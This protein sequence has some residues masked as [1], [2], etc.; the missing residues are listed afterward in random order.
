MG[1]KLIEGLPDGGFFGRRNG[2]EAVEQRPD[3]AVPGKVLD[4]E[5]FKELIRR[6]GPDIRLGLLTQVCDLCLHGEGEK[7]TLVATEDGSATHPQSL[8]GETLLDYA[9]ANF[10]TS[11]N[12]EGLLTASSARILRL[13]STCFL[14]RPLTSSE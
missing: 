14:S 7:N 1:A 11:A 6:Y 3:Q 5:F 8:P 9:R 10:T 12:A 13:M 2:L 4:T